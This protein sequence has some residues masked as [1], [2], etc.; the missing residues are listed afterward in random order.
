MADQGLERSAAGDH[1]PWMV[2]TIV[3]MATFMEVLDTSIANV[4]LQHI[5]GGMAASQEEST[6]ILTSY[7]VSNAIVLPISGWL[8][9]VIGRKRFYMGCVA[10]F[11]ASSLLCG[12]A[13]SLGWLVV[14]RILQG[15][16]GGGLAPSEQ[17]ILADSFPPERRGQAFAL[18]GVAVVVAPTLGPTLGGWI[19]DTYSWRW[20]FL[21]NVPV[22]LLSLFLSW[23]ILVD[24]PA[25]EQ[26]RKR[27]AGRWRQCD[28]LGAALVALGLGC[29]QVVLDKG[30]EDDWFGS[31]FIVVFALISVIALVALIVWELA[32]EHPIVDLPL[33]R[34]RGFGAAMAAMFATGFILISTTQVI[35]QFLQSIMGYD[36]TKAGLA[37]TAGGCATLVMMPLAGTLT[38]KIQ[39]KYLIAFGLTV[40]CLACLYLRGFNTSVDFWHA[41]VGRIFQAAGLPFLFVPITTVSYA[42]LPPE[43]SPN[44]SALINTMRNLGGSFGI[45]VAVAILARRGQ[46]HHA[47]LSEAVTPFSPLAWRHLL[48]G[49]AAIAQAL[50]RQ[51]EML[52][53]LDLFTLLAVV[54]AAIVPVTLL[55]Q[56]IDLKGA[57]AGA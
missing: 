41:A 33:A 50:E 17:S 24:P 57:Q 19:T 48:G 16:G 39:P 7:L 18:Y 14:F 22:C 21:I 55:L 30:T 10:L 29:L 56:K 44:A 2:A 13:P 35:P 12:L 49:P 1:N 23:R 3:S 4:S 31:D 43:K 6:W 26:D 45:S 46:F 42:G 54:A 32:Q 28:W 51:A 27:A 37:L 5:A 36:A 9:H 34:H 52:S 40:E 25:V 47:R 53:Y 11:G 38:R 20:I 15:L 8:S